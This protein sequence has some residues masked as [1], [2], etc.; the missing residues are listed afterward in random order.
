MST[1]PQKKTV[2]KVNQKTYRNPNIRPPVLLDPLAGVPM[3][4]EITLS[5][6]KNGPRKIHEPLKER[7]ILTSAA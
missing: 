2:G 6:R 3:Q 7:P 5:T 4:G 1:S